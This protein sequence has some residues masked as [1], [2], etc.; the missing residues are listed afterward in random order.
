MFDPH[1]GPRIYLLF[2]ACCASYLHFRCDKVLVLNVYLITIHVIEWLVLFE[3]CFSLAQVV[4]GAYL[5]GGASL[6]KHSDIRHFPEKCK[7]VHKNSVSSVTTVALETCHMTALLFLVPA[8][9]QC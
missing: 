5:G 4:G 9:F 2:A 7:A 8:G 6:R 1:P 3:G